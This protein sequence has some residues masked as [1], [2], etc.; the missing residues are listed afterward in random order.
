MNTINIDYYGGSGGFLTLWIVLLGTSY[1]CKFDLDYSLDDIFAKHWDIKSTDKWKDTEVWPNNNTTAQSNFKEKV[2]FFCSP[3]QEEWNT[4]LG[5]KILIYTDYSTQFKLSK[6]KNSFMF[7]NNP[8]RDF[9]TEH[10]L[11][12]LT[13]AYENIRDESWPDTAV[14]TTVK[15]FENLQSYIKDELMECLGVDSFDDI[16][17]S[18]KYIYKDSAV[19]YELEGKLETADLAI[20]LQDLVRTRGK[21]LLDYLGYPSNQK[22]DDFIDFWLDKHPV[23]IRNLLDE[24]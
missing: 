9:E 11:R 20:K 8:T 6:L 12:C 1:R 13:T 18:L 2:L 3:T 23:E 14:L 4:R 7:F 22:V 10:I 19:W 21:I 24:K 15:D 16:V 5:K 17:N